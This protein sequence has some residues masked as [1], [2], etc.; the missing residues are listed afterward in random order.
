[1]ING[2][3]VFEKQVKQKTLN[4]LYELGLCDSEAPIILHGIVCRCDFS[5]V[6]IIMVKQYGNRGLCTS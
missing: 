5:Q 1:V 2:E 6:L 3:R 4:T